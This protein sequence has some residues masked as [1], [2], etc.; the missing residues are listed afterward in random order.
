MV[1]DSHEYFTEVPELVSRPF[2]RKIWLIIEKLLVPRVDVAITVGDNISKIY[3]K[4]YKNQFHVVR[5][6]PEIKSHVSKPFKIRLYFISRSI[7]YGQG[8][9]SS[10][11]SNENN[12]HES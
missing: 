9:R 4:K 5:N 12:S 7:K 2:V 3:T 10:Y 1:Y 6:C 11:F 8:T